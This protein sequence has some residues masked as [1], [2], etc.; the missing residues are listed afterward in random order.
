M[1]VTP[2][3]VRDFLRAKAQ[4]DDDAAVVQAERLR[5]AAAELCRLIVAR[6]GVRRV[7]LFGSLAWGS[8]ARDADIDLAVEGLDGSAYFAALG[9]LLAAAPVAVDLVRLEDAPPGLAARIL[10]EGRLIHD[11]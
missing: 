2:S 7:W 8:P 4:S 5:A 10:A 1:P 6:P 11:G 9:E 3:D